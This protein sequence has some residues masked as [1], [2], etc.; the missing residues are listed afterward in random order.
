MRS[1]RLNHN[2]LPLLRFVQSSDA[3]R[4]RERRQTASRIL[5]DTASIWMARGLIDLLDDPDAIV[6]ANAA[7]ALARLTN[8]THGLSPEDWQSNDEKRATGVAAWNE[9]WQLHRLTC[10]PPPEGVQLPRKP[11]DESEMILKARN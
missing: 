3:V 10:A 1:N 5:V 9:W 4:D 7:R 6:R 8:E 11:R 2:W